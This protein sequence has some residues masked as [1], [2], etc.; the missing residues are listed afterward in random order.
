MIN[1]YIYIYICVCE[2]RCFSAVLQSEYRG[3]REG[4]VWVFHSADAF[5]YSESYVEKQLC[6]FSTPRSR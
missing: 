1:I 2:I 5:R 4:E 6:C 3:A